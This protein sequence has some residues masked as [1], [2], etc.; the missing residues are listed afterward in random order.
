MRQAAAPHARRHGPAPVRLRVLAED[1]R[2]AGRSV[3]GSLPTSSARPRLGN[4]TSIPRRSSRLRSGTRLAERYV[5]AMDPAPARAVKM[6]VRGPQG[7]LAGQ[8]PFRAGDRHCSRHHPPEMPAGAVLSHR[9]YDRPADRRGRM[10]DLSVQLRRHR[11]HEAPRRTPSASAGK[12][13]PG[14]CTA[15]RKRDN[16]PLPGA[17]S[18]AGTTINA[19]LRR[20]RGMRDEQVLVLKLKWATSHPIRSLRD[21]E[22]F[23]AHPTLHLNR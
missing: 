2:A 5:A 13:G 1:R 21:L 11:V 22:R 19:I 8:D 17:P 10:H 4:S 3:G 12:S 7:T 18:T 14:R 20:A 15:R 9:G 23:L 6:H 16:Q